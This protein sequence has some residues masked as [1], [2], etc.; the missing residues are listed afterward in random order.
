MNA[1]IVG[2]CAIVASTLVVLV[3]LM[4]LL[5]KTP[6]Y[7]PESERCYFADRAVELDDL[8]IGKEDCFG[9]PIFTYL[10]FGTGPA[11]FLS[12]SKACSGH[13]TELARLKIA[14]EKGDGAGFWAVPKI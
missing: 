2:V 8:T 5:G 7:E 12:G 13:G 3:L 6:T 1:T 4:L 11:A 9:E 14:I 10:V